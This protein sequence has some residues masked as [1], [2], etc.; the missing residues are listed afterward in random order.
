MQEGEKYCLTT[1]YNDAGG[2]N[3]SKP[4]KEPY[5]FLP[6]IEYSLNKNRMGIVELV[7][8]IQ[9]GLNIIQSNQF[10]DI[11]EFVNSYLDFQIYQKLKRFPHC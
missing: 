5:K 2:K 4:E 7:M 11:V 10:D 6:L 9:D 8:A 1:T 3:K